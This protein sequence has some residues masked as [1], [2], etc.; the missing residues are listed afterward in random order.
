MWWEQVA[1]YAKQRTELHRV[2]RRTSSS[3]QR[4]ECPQGILSVEDEAF[5]RTEQKELEEKGIYCY[6][7]MCVSTFSPF[8][9]KKK[10]VGSCHCGS[11]G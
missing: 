10:K 7:C 9:F 1:E 2:F 5:P 11:A 8:S 4:G 6:S 3:R